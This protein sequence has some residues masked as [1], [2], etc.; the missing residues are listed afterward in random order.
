MTNNILLALPPHDLHDIQGNIV[1]S[2]WLNSE[3]TSIIGSRVLTITQWYEYPWWKNLKRISNNRP[4][5]RAWT[6]DGCISAF[7]IPKEEYLEKEN[8]IRVVYSDR[9]DCIEYF[10][11]LSKTN[12]PRLEMEIQ[13]GLEELLSNNT[14]TV[15]VEIPWAVKTVVKDWKAGW[16]YQRAGSPYTNEEITNWS[17]NPLKGENISLI[18]DAYYINGTGWIRGPILSAQNLL[19]IKYNISMS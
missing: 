18:G 1:S 5:W 3:L 9:L 4:V 16:H 19:K 14:I 17:V 8:V 7:E 15:P 13:K 2:L 10:V 12:K 6:Q 11:F